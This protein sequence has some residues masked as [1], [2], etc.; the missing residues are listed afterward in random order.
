MGYYNPIYIYGVDQ[1][2]SD[3]L[4]VGVDGLII[5]DLPPEEDRE[6]AKPCQKAGMGCI[7]LATPTT[8]EKR[9]GQ[10]LENA[11]GFLY[12]VS[13]AGITGTREP[14]LKPVEQAISMI[15]KQS[16]LPVA[17]GFGI[18]TPDMAGR[19]AQISDAVVVGSAIVNV[20]EQ[21]LK[22]STDNSQENLA[23]S[24]LES[25][26]LDFV[27]SLAAAVHKARS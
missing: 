22:N 23:N 2:L 27:N 7:H 19:F 21:N 24:E 20:I 26:V 11:S 13:I 3:A 14:D 9:L 15:R 17:V 25:R 5:V 6:L 10:I 16:R 4:D 12:Y 18:K 1:F 8:D